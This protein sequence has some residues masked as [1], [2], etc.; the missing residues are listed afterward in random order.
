LRRLLD[1][2]KY[3][4]LSRERKNGPLGLGVKDNDELAIASATESV[5]VEMSTE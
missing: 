1:V 2:R 4:S 5:D 3:V